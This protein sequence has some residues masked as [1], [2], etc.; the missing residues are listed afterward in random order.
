MDRELEEFKQALD[1]IIARAQPSKLRPRI[2][3]SWL[4]ALKRQMSEPSRI[5]E[6]AA[7]S[8][9]TATPQSL[10]QP[11]RKKSAAPQPNKRKK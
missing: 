2:T 1:R 4:E 10:Q 8:S 9:Q 7:P 3:K 11:G 5:S 6:E